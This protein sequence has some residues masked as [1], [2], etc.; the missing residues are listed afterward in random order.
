MLTRDKTR[1]H[2]A[3]AGFGYDILTPARLMRLRELI[4]TEMRRSGLSIHASRSAVITRAPDG[5]PWAYIRCLSTHFTNRECV[6]FN[7]DGFVGFA[8]W[9][10]DTNVQPILAAFCAW[11]DE[12]SANDKEAA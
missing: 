11:V 1:A 2:W 9:A 7:P 3:N 6:T 10:D 12:I 5:R 4:D 8:G